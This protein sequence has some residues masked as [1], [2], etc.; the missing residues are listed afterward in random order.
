M[1]KLEQIGELR[2]IKAEVS[3]DQEIAEILR[4]LVRDGGPAV[5]FENVKGYRIPVLGNAFGTIERVKVA[6]QTENFEDLGKKITG[7]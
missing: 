1:R 3:V 6:L 4:R 5:L 2:R 7:M